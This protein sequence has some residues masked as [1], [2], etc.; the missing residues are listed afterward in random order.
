MYET[1]GNTLQVNDE[2]GVL[3]GGRHDLERKGTHDTVMSGGLRTSE[4]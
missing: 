4:A 1:V 2:S 3:S